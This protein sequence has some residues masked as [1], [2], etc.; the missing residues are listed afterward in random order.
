MY[1]EAAK[2][3]KLVSG[4]KHLSFSASC[5]YLDAL[6]HRE[7][8]NVRPSLGSAP[9][10]VECRVPC[11]RVSRFDGLCALASALHERIEGLGNVRL[12]QEAT[13]GVGR[14]QRLARLRD[15]FIEDVRERSWVFIARTYFGAACLTVLRARAREVRRV[16]AG[17]SGE[18]GKQR[19]NLLV[20]S[21]PHAKPEQ[22]TP[23]TGRER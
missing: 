13:N 15:R 17:A 3:V 23:A 21:L 7:L 14:E 9:R 20:M 16:S 5:S 8:A 12:T 18:Q 10:C 11:Q 6:N 22:A 1:S 4:G 19:G 2:Q